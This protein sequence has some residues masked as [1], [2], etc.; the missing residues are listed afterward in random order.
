MINNI[1]I[2][3]T[4]LIIITI[5]FFTFIINMP[6]SSL[7]IVIIARFNKFIIIIFKT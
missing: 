5:T 6:K 2:I 4:N 7:I 1:I 3:G